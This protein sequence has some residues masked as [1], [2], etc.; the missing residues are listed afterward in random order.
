MNSAKLT[1]MTAFKPTPASLMT[2]A[3]LS[4]MRT[5]GHVKYKRLVRIDD[6]TSRYRTISH[7]AIS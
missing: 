5:S 1:Y 6:T 7:Q 4:G 3:L 2:A